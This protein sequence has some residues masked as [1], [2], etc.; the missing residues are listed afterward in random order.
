[1]VNEQQVR[2]AAFWEEES[3]CLHCGA[4]GDGAEIE[5]CCDAPRLI[6]PKLAVAVIEMVEREGEGSD[7]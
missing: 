5:F 4:V 3:I 6:D 7:L 2:D 1:M